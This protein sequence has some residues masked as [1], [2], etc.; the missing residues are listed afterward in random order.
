MSRA[1]W[2]NLVV[3]VMLYEPGSRGLDT[4]SRMTTVVARVDR[5]T[6]SSSEKHSPAVD[7][8]PSGPG[9]AL[10]ARVTLIA[11]SPDPAARPAAVPLAPEEVAAAIAAALAGLVREVTRPVQAAGP[12]ADPEITAPLLA[13]SPAAIEVSDVVPATRE[14]MLPAPIAVSSEP[15]APPLPEPVPLAPI[16]AFTPAPELER[17]ELPPARPLEGPVLRPEPPPEAAEVPSAGWRHTARR[18][19]RIAGY[20]AAGYFA[21]V[22]VLIGVYRFVDPPFSTLMLWRWVG[23]SEINQTWVPIGNISPNLVRAVIV[24]EDGRFCS[25]RGI[26]IAAMKEAVE[27]SKTI[28]PRGAS[29]ISM[30]VAKNIFLWPSKSYVRKV[31]EVPVTLVMEAVWPKWRILE[32]YLN[33]AEWGEG[34]FGAEAAAQHHFRKSSAR[35]GEREAAQLAVALPNPFRRDAGAPGPRVAQRATVIQGRARAEAE[36]ADCVLSALKPDE[37]APEKGTGVREGL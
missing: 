25:H 29:T 17:K 20:A 13:P 21:L 16:P 8:M 5:D 11:E 37:K 1:L 24:S 23:G 28:Y 22:L 34:V 2:A 12:V 33:V 32:V 7:E 4:R 35:L 6:A 9:N 18:A 14:E 27:R 30:Q 31:V 36:A 10:A 19:V 3:K 15:A 26:D